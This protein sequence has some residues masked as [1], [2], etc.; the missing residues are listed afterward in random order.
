MYF[1]GV[2]TRYSSIRKVFPEWAKELGLR[3]AQLRGIDLPLHADAKKYRDVICFIRQDLLSYGALVT[4]HKIDLFQACSDLF[5]ERDRFAELMQEVS[6]ISKRENRLV[7]QAKDPISAGRTLVQMLPEGYWDR[8]TADV[9]CFGAGGAGVA[10]LW[11]LLYGE[12]RLGRPDHVYVSDI[13]LSRLTHLTKLVQSDRLETRLVSNPDESDRLLGRLRPGSLVI[14]ATGLGKDRPGSPIRDSAEF[15]DR[16]IV[17]ELNYRGEL[18]FLKQARAQQTAKEL[19]I[20]DG[21]DY[22]IHGWTCVIGDVFKIE[23]DPDS[24]ARLS[25]IATQA[26]H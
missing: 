1:I 22:F 6:S 7:A 18:D 20:Y 17:W 5:D 16:A 13:S 24:F 23:I 26:S 8:G 2:S 14:N 11:F 3:D 19:S 4:T 12:H 15:P 10:I 9:L 25:E 21:W